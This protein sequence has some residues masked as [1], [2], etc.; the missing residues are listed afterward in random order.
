METNRKKWGVGIFVMTLL[1][2][3][4]AWT[5]L[6]GVVGRLRAEYFV[7]QAGEALEAGNW[8]RAARL[9][10]SAYYLDT[11]RHD[12]ALITA[13]AE[14]K[15][16]SPSTVDW[17]RRGL[18]VREQP[19][20]ELRTLVTMLVGSGQKTEALLFMNRLLLED[21]NGLETQVLWM[22]LMESLKRY[23]EVLDTSRNI[24]DRDSTDWAVHQRYVQLQ[25]GLGGEEGKQMAVRHL[26]NLI[27]NGGPLAL[28]SARML[29]RA[30]EISAEARISGGR[31]LIE[32]SMSELD[33]IQGFRALGTNEW[34]VAQKKYN[35]LL[36]MVEGDALTDAAK[37]AVGIREYGWLLEGISIEE[38]IARAADPSPYYAACL[39]NEQYEKLITAT[40]SRLERD[41][42]TNAIQLYYRGMGLVGLGR[43]DEAHASFQ[44]AVDVAEGEEI[45]GLE[46]LLFA[47]K[48][49]DQL[50]NLYDRV[51][52]DYPERTSYL[53]KAL[54]VAYHRADTAKIERLLE[55]VDVTQLRQQPV[56]EA[57]VVYLNLLTRGWDTT[58]HD[59]LEALLA[60]YPQT[61]EF[62]LLLGMS[63]VLAGKKDFG[64]GFL[65]GMPQ[66]GQTAPRFIRVCAAFL[67]VDRVTVLEPGEWEL[68]MP[69]E[70]LLLLQA[71]D[72]R[73]GFVSHTAE[74]S[75]RILFH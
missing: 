18:A 51:T 32:N 59:R 40:E 73:R 29:S 1:M 4:M 53:H 45:A 9:G 27:Q 31:Y 57:F 11:R 5:T 12:A 17:W 10:S 30:W 37:W 26:K 54:S 49:W 38:Y 41:V 50:Q 35:E 25:I 46:A 14:L 68:L 28:E 75:V 33:T 65:E 24:V 39:A 36:G 55:L 7:R 3:V 72:T 13:R 8:Q 56:L 58:T 22:R 62:R 21:P 71:E 19:V 44:L 52:M 2:L 48:K 66:L 16:Q 34:I 61:F 69:R 43:T 63:Y 23:H 47:G 74:R 60:E 64:V 42:T 6:T 70:R 67:G 20:D 15:Q